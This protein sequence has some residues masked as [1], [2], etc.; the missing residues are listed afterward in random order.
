MC[1]ACFTNPENADLLRHL[2]S[3]HLDVNL[4]DVHVGEGVVCL[5][6][7]TLSGVLAGYQKYNWK[8]DKKKRNDEHGKYYTYRG[9]KV[10]PKHSKTVSVW[11]LE[12]WYLSTTL[13]VTEGVFDAARFTSLGYSAVAVLSNNP[14]TSTKNWFRFVRQTRPVVSVCD[15]GPTGRKLAMLGHQSV[16]VNVP[17]M[18]DADLGDAP[19][20]YVDELVKEYAQ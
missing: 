2:E 12:S 20:S 6:L 4:H 7:Y 10:L 1:R 16:T 5:Y 11:G 18:P 19:Q 17:G 3:R 8:S 14:S 9:E 13:F 15:P